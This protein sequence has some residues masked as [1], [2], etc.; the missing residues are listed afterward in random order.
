MVLCIKANALIQTEVKS[1]EKST[2]S[3]NQMERGRGTVPRFKGFHP[4]IICPLSTALSLSLYSKAPSKEHTEAG[5]QVV[6]PGANR[7]KVQNFMFKWSADSKLW[8]TCEPSLISHLFSQGQLAPR[9]R[10]GGDPS[11]GS[12]EAEGLNKTREAAAGGQI[13]APQFTQTVNK[14]ALLTPECLQ[15]T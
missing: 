10:H 6:L 11:H 2:A 8:L 5:S 7:P 13:Q 12:C 15:T 1:Q 14:C 4:R 3:P 9:Q